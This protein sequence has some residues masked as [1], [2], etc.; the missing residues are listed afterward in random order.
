MT[1]ASL[2]P[3]A[4]TALMHVADVPRSI[5]FYGRLGFDVGNTFTPQ[6][7]GRPVWAWLTSQRAHLMVTQ[8][9]EPVAAAQQAVL[10]YLYCD[11][12]AAYRTQLLTRGVA[13][14]PIEVQHYAPF[15]QFRLD[16]DGYVVMVS[17]T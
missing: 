5:A 14:G 1:D 2:R 16:P 3:V 9:D 17:H 6:G 15:G 12:V 13:C 10:F 7:G 4:I 11:D 8:A